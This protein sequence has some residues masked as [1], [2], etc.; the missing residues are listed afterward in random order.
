MKK[1]L[2]TIIL[3]SIYGCASS[4]ITPAKN[5]LSDDNNVT[6]QEQRN[7]IFNGLKTLPNNT[8]VA[9]ALIENGEV[10]YFGT[11]RE[12]DSLNYSKNNNG[13]FEIG[14]ITKVF[15]ATLLADSVVNGKISLDDKINKYIKVPIKGDTQISFK[16]L[17][18]H[19][20]GLP[21]MPS[22]FSMLSVVLNPSNPFKSYDTEKLE[23]Y[24]TKHVKLSSEPGEKLEYSNIGMA[25]L[26]YALCHVE[27]EGCP[28][29]NEN[30][31]TLLET[32]I[33]S[34]YDMRNSTTKWRDVE[35]KLVKGR[36]GKG[37]ETVN[38]DIA[39]FA[40]AGAILSTVEDLTKF[41]LAQFDPLNEVLALTRVKTFTVNERSSVSLGW[42][43]GLLNDEFG[44][45]WYA[46]NGGTGGYSSSIVIDPKT[47]N[48]VVILSNISTFYKDSWEITKLS[49][50]LMNTIE[51]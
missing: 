44:E 43:Q 4:P 39:A 17:A 1:Y 2:L 21:R 3:L 46:H 36:N 16:E 12:E 34:K 20:S 48:G 15:T 28:N 47:K 31:H 9:I 50:E 6:T 18:N 25:A 35:H 38:M 30:Y 29:L 19:T 23:Q 51:R 42:G 33:F 22:N 8:E 11:K 7:L 5:N 10:G 13:V 24:L 26:A 49:H 41:T 45:N 37:E 14:S 27:T 32:R 40:G